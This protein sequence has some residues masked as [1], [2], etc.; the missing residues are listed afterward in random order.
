MF[1]TALVFASALAAMTPP[2]TDAAKPAPKKTAATAKTDP[3]LT[4]AD[5]AELEAA[6]TKLH[7]AEARARKFF[8][9]GQMKRSHLKALQKQTDALND[10]WRPCTSTSCLAN[11][12]CCSGVCAQSCTEPHGHG[13]GH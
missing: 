2:P 9:S 7:A 3:S 10:I 11:E 4:D 1:V 13:H 12:T 6:L 8:Q 5:Q